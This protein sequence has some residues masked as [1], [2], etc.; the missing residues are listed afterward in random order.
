[1]RP[2][3]P[4]FRIRWACLGEGGNFAFLEAN[5][6]LN[7]WDHP[8]LH[9]LAVDLRDGS[10]REIGEVSG[11]DSAMR[12]HPSSLLLGTGTA[13]GRWDTQY[14]TVLVGSGKGPTVLLDGRTGRELA[15]PSADARLEAHWKRLRDFVVSAP[16]RYFNGGLKV[17][18]RDGKLETWGDTGQLKSVPWNLENRPFFPWGD[19][20]SFVPSGGD[21]SRCHFF[22]LNLMAVV[23]P[24]WPTRDY[25]EL[26]RG[27]RWILSKRDDP[28]EPVLFDPVTRTFEEA[29]FLKEDDRL[30]STLE[31]G[32][33][34]VGTPV[35]TDGRHRLELV[36][37]ETAA[38]R[39]LFFEDHSPAEVRRCGIG[40]N[41]LR[42]PGGRPILRLFLADGIRYGRV[43][44]VAGRIDRL[45]AFS[46]WVGGFVACFDEESAL[47]VT[48]TERSLG[49]ARFGGDEVEI[50]F[51]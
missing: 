16:G 32:D 26:I 35:G 27:D 3:D 42:T 1:M 50:L 41:H 46:P 40:L 37:P 8:P 11:P 7:A 36:S 29:S 30:V 10:W 24:D 34:V 6:C 44:G 33:L 47:V 28:P 4:G 5:N 23:E 31:C 38:R 17:W 43:D 39:P 45:P 15:I 14:P 21:P 48:E 18:F 9:T 13:L 19:G 51:P 25:I 20:F 22:D 49:R 2:E 12:N